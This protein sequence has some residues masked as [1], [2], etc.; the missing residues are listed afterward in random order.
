[1]S[2]KGVVLIYSYPFHA[3]NS[4]SRVSLISSRRWDGLI[5]GRW[6]C[7]MWHSF[8]RVGGISIRIGY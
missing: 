3:L 2:R 7:K 6:C 1:M 8:G 4:A 5:Q